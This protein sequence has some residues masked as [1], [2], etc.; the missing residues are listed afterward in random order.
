[1]C[2]Y[3]KVLVCVAINIYIRKDRESNEDSTKQTCAIS[4][5]LMRHRNL[6]T[7]SL[8]IIFQV[9]GKV[10]HTRTHLQISIF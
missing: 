7:D 5:G 6:R 8:V 2:V 9:E 4:K 10:I 3:C 1:M